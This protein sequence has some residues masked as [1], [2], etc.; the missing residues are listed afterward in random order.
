M[1]KMSVIVPMYNVE[2]YIRDCID[3]IAAQTLADIEII[4]V[5]DGS[6]DESGRIADDYASQDP[7]IRVYHKENGG[8]GAARNDG[9]KLA[10]GEYVLFCDGDDF[11]EPYACETLY[12][13]ALAHDAD[14]AVGD[15]Y[16]IVNGEKVYARFWRREFTTCSRKTLDDLIRTDFSRKFC[17]DVPKEGPAFGY[18]GPWNKAVRRTFLLE[19]GICFEESLKGIFDDILYT[20]YLYA[21]AGCVTYVQVPV[22]DYRILDDS[23]THSFKPDMPAINRAIFA[24]WKK[25]LLKYGR[26]GRFME[27]YYAL[28]IRRLKGLLGTYYFHPDNPMSTRRQKEELKALLRT[29]PYHAAVNRADPARLI[30]AYDLA[31][32][33]AAKA[34]S[35]T[36]IQAVYKA[37]CV[38]KKK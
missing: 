37:F 15:V 14:V 35:V 26:D 9:L 36:G 11:M 21:E 23:I 13:A 4:L 20:A 30:N 3:S 28:V 19:K 33:T 27:A 34:G 8:V 31:V 12:E 38:I 16:R 2:T 24:A 1:P 10:S 17:H 5:D 7:R 6:P 18:G 32:W 25:F 22:Y 29:Q